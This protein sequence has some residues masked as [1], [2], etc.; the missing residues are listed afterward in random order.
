MKNY[1]AKLASV[2]DENPNI[3]EEKKQNIRKNLNVLLVKFLKSCISQARS[4]ANLQEFSVDEQDVIKYI[5]L[6][7]NTL[8]I[9]DD[10][11]NEMATLYS[12]K[13]TKNKVGNMFTRGRHY[14]I[15]H[16]H[17][18]QDDASLAPGLRKNAHI[19]VLTQANLAESFINRT[20]N[21]IGKEDQK[22]GIRLVTSLFQSPEDRRKIIYFK[23]APG[24]KKFQY[25]AAKPRGIFKTNNDAVNAYC[26]KVSD[27]SSRSSDNALF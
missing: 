24:D 23:Q 7:H 21:N 5:D 13:D 9:F 2:H 11:Q 20:S 6:D 22:N 4:G 14:G 19:S 17:T 16:W 27:S 26:D 8:V 18:L 15:T 10:V 12:R 25:Y 3:A 1:E